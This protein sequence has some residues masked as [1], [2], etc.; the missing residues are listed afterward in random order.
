MVNSKYFDAATKA[1]ADWLEANSGLLRVSQ[2]L[3]DADS[4]LTN[5]HAAL[6]HA[7]AAILAARRVELATAGAAA[8]RARVNYGV[9]LQLERGTDKMTAPL[10]SD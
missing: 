9:R 8:R 7:E 4:A 10:Q 5:A 2:A 1:E 6:K 3:R